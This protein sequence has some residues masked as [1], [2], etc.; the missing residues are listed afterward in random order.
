MEQPGE[1]SNAKTPVQQTQNTTLLDTG[2]EEKPLL[3]VYSF[4]AN[5]QR[6]SY[7]PFVTKLHFRLRYSGIPYINKF[8][9]WF[10]APKGKIPYVEFHETGEILG[11]SGLIVQRL[12]AMDAAVDRGSLG[13]NPSFLGDCDIKS[14]LGVRER[15][16]DYC[17]R[18]AVEE[19]GY[20]VTVSTTVNFI[21]SH[22]LLGL[23][24]PN[25]NKPLKY[26]GNDRPPLK[27]ALRTMVR[28]LLRHERPRSVFWSAMGNPSCRG[29]PGVSLC[30]GDFIY[31]RRGAVYRERSDRAKRGDDWDVG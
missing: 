9:S 22:S 19:G 28:Q 2:Q 30:Q 11:D 12:V 18:K 25:W 24:L 4:D 13:K 1:H 21:L 8:G 29:R 26:M 15:A 10:Q 14:G 6:Y 20:F 27:I 5:P 3:T 23:A 7:S 31:A 17:L 16:M